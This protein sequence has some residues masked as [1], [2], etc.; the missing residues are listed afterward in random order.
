MML[1]KMKIHFKNENSQAAAMIV[2]T[3]GTQFPQLQTLGFSMPSWKF[4]G[5]LREPE[6]KS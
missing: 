6:P 3:N 5:D 1:E 4:M 2:L